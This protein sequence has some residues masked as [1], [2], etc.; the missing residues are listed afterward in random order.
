MLCGQGA[1]AVG[2]LDMT[3]WYA[4]HHTFRGGFECRDR[5]AMRHV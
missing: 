4:M 2:P 3:M 5:K 1:T